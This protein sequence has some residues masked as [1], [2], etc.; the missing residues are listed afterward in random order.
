MR[1][2][3]DEMTMKD[4]ILGMTDDLMADFLF[5]DRKE[6]DEFPRGVIESAIK[7]GVISVDEIVA[8]F[9]SHLEGALD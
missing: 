9:R 5:Y 1:K 8:C 2:T 6:D 3:W 7:N 4:K